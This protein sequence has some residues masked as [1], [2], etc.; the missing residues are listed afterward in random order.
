M[1]QQNRELEP[2][3]A[4]SAMERT[5]EEKK[6]RIDRH[7]KQTKQLREHHLTEVEEPHCM[8]TSSNYSCGHDAVHPDSG[9]HLTLFPESVTCGWQCQSRGC[10]VRRG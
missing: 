7:L 3:N 9:R 5:R 1:G 6:T 10:L 8:E 4:E 2:V